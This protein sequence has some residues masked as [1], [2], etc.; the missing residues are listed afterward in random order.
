MATFAPREPAKERI[1]AA[2][3]SNDARRRI[4]MTAQPQPVV[5]AGACSDKFVKI[6]SDFAEERYAMVSPCP[7]ASVNR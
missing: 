2:A 3:C 4:D 5:F 1:N 7:L 6:A